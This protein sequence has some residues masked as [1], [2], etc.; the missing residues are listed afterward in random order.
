LL[1]A[2]LL[3]SPNLEGLRWVLGGFGAFF[4][5]CWPDSSFSCCAAGLMRQVR[6]EPPICW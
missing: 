4:G 5:P 6:G 3:V 2:G 1:P